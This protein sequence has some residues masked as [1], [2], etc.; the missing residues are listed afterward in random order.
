MNLMVKK[1]LV[2][3]AFFLLKVKRILKEHRFNHRNSSNNN[4][5]FCSYHS[6]ANQL[7]LK[8]NPK[9]QLKLRFINNCSNRNLVILDKIA[10]LKHRLQLHL[11]NHFKSISLRNKCRKLNGHSQLIHKKIK[12]FSQGTQI[13]NSNFRLDKTTTIILFNLCRL[14]NCNCKFL[15]MLTI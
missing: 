10:Q 13:I 2:V 9:E 3:I 14:N 1:C 8:D 12:V 5:H 7:R 15:R 11:N 4:N 6:Q